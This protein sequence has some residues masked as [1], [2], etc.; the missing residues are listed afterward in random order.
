M[1]IPTLS[2][3]YITSKAPS[4]RCH[5]QVGSDNVG[6]IVLGVMIHDIKVDKVCLCS[7]LESH[8]QTITTLKV[9]HIVRA[10]W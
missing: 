3:L 1:L 6:D 2:K 10:G 8:I 9:H 4:V 5:I 7:L